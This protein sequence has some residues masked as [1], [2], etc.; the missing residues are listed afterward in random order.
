MKDIRSLT[1]I[2]DTARPDWWIVYATQ[3]E[4]MDFARRCTYSQSGVTVARDELR[5][6]VS[7]RIA[8]IGRAG[9]AWA[10]QELTAYLGSGKQT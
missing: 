7:R 2:L 3:H 5:Y 8:E 4:L 10:D 1:K 9:V 6:D